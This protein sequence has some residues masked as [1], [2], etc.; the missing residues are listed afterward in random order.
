M[1]FSFPYIPG[2]DDFYYIWHRASIFAVNIIY[3]PEK[4]GEFSEKCQYPNSPCTEFII[5]YYLKL[6]AGRP[7]SQKAWKFVSLPASWPPSFQAL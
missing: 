6:K 7:G 1:K 3:R 5:C 4:L 2:I